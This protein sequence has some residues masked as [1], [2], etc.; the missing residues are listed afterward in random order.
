M[1]LRN[2]RL[3]DGSV[4]DLLL[5]DDHGLVR[6]VAP[7]GELPPGPGASDGMDETVGMDLAGF[8]LLPAP[9]E[10]HAHLDKALT[11]DLVG[12]PPGDL[13][14]AVD[15]WGAFSERV[16]EEDVARRARRALDELTMNGVTAVRTHAN[17][18]PGDDP[19]RGLRALLRLRDDE[20][21][22]R[23][24]ELQIVLLHGEAPEELLREALRMGVDVLGGCPHLASDPAAAVDQALRLAG[25]FGVP[26]D[27]HADENLDPRSRDLKLLADR[28][29]ERP[30]PG[31]TASHCVS[32]GVVP[33]AEA[34]AL[35]KEV[36]AAGIAVV[37]LPLTNL[38][39]QGRDHPAPVPRG[40]TAV[41]ALLDAGVTL[42]AGGDN[43]R[44]PFNPVGRFD[45]LETAG[46]MV[47]AGHLTPDE[48][49]HAVTNAARAVLGLPE[50]GPWAGAVADLL[51][52]RA[53]SVS[54]ALGQG[55]AERVVF[56]AGRI[57]SRTRVVRE[58]L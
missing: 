5:C 56:K 51:A 50:A 3:P 22:R 9:A 52:V 37:T 45:G 14:A 34:A 24:V 44:D 49:L 27:L 4:R 46:L 10:P 53:D 21:V 47:A 30:R 16:T 29:R 57:V 32:L 39:L 7:P 20:A 18:L 38:F 11:W 55:A 17:L 25:E 36:A 1:L 42:A 48:A 41:R 13:R 12:A 58:L 33:D 40:L 15:A 19:L 6:E 8:L 28:L 43:V 35:A 26:L 23:R 31:V 54:E 2:A